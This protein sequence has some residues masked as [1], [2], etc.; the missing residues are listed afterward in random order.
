MAEKLGHHLIACSLLP[1]PSL[2]I[3]KDQTNLLPSVSKARRR[4][5]LQAIT[6]QIYAAMPC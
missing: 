6:Y 3:S 4:H 5:R 1:I 2:G